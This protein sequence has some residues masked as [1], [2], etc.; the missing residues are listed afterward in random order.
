MKMAILLKNLII[1]MRP[2][3]WFKNFFI[4]A[5]LIFAKDF[6]DLNKVLIS[7]AAFFLFCFASSAVYLIN[8]VID[9]E[10][11]KQHPTKSKRPIA[12]GKISVKT[13]L[14]FFIFL[15]AGAIAG[16]FC[17]NNYFGASLA[18]Y[19]ALNILYSV[20]LK[21]MVIIDVI[22]IALGFVIRVVAGA[23]AIRVY[24]SP[25]LIFCTFFLTLFLAVS[26]RKSELIFYQNE[27]SARPVLS[28]Y[29]LEFIEKINTVVFS[30]VLISY[31]LYT[32]SSVHGVW[33]M[34]TIPVVLY[35][36]L[37][38]FFISDKKRIPDDGPSD[39]LLRDRPLQLTILIWV[40]M[41]LFIIY[42][43]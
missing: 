27:Q 18:G 28:Q 43:E 17:I 29:S 6:T 5:A 22:T 8:D 40:I 20:A 2:R 9:L 23:L 15:S 21:R 24:F 25:W 38:Y 14:V 16:S 13:A 33:L 42:Y 41:L 37:R 36:L 10:Y 35:G 1:S 34:T 31:A 32:F 26:K 11:D 30:S 12:S 19:I 4:F 3:Q 39:D 7:F